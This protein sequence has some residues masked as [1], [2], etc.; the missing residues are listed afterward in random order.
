MIGRLVVLVVLGAL[1]AFPWLG[2]PF[3]TE[4]LTSR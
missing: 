4:L 2:M 1:V 3:Y